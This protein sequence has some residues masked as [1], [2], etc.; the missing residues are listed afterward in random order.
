MNARPYRWVYALIAYGVLHRDLEQLW[1]A[2]WALGTPGRAVATV[3]YISCLAYRKDENPAFTPWTRNGGGGPPGLWEF[4]GHLNTHRWLESNV[5]FLAGALE[6]SR[7][8]EVLHAAVA[9]LANEPEGNEAVRVVA[10]LAARTEILAQRCRE[11]PRILAEPRQPGV[12]P[13]WSR[14]EAT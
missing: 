14:S 3:Q 4:A 6:P 10:G 7:V 2:W 12:L 9:R 8:T 11:L 13:Q 5:R 1:S